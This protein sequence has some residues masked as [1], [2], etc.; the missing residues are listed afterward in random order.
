MKKT[1]LLLFAFA[2]GLSSCEEQVKS[3]DSKEQEMK[4]ESTNPLLMEST[5]DYYAPDFSKI[6][7]SHYR[8]ALEEGIR[9]KRAEIEE[10]ANQS[11]EPTFENTLVALERSGGDLKRVRSVFGALTSAHTNDTLQALKQEFAPIFSELN[12]EVYLNSALFD[13]I[14]TLYD[15]KEDLSLDAESAKLLDEYYNDFVLAGAELEG[16]AKEKLKAVNSEMASLVAKFGET[17]LAA[18]N[19]GALIVENAEELKGL[20]ESKLK[21]IETE[22]GNYKIAIQNTTQQ[23]TLVALENRKMRQKVFENAWY[24]TDG[25]AHDTKDII[26]KIAQKRAEKAA[27]LGYDSYA[28]WSLQNTMIQSKSNLREFFDGLI[29]AAIEKASAE[30]QLIE[31]MMHREGQEG[32]LEPW[33]WNFYAE[34]VRKEKYDLDENEIKPY[35]EMMSVLENGVFYAAEKL[36]G[37]TFKERTD[38][39][40][41][42]EDVLVY[43]LFE[44]DGSKLG[45]FYADFYSRES[46]RGGAWMGNFVD[47]SHLLGK[48]PVI[49]NVCNYPKPAEGEPTLLSFDNA[50]T[51]FH[52]FGHALHGFFANQEYPSLSGT[53]VARDFVEFPSQF[54][55]NWATHPD[56]LNNYAKHYETGEVIPA[57]LL[58]KIQEAATFNQG[59]SITENLAASNLDYAWHTISADKTIEDANQFEKDALSKYGVDKVRAVKPRYRSTYFAHIFAGGYGAGYYSYLWTEM[60]HHDAYVWFENNGGLTRENGQRYRDMVLSVGNTLQYDELYRDWSGR[61]PKIEPMIKARGLK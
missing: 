48:K 24:R 9:L 38:I 15:Q 20:S 56:V 59:Y 30:S 13:R 40:V 52:E 44:E 2:V 26:V 34:K 54:N 23:P 7:N 10:I 28:D 4:S 21:S 47:Q 18:T 12:D 41:Y 3:N 50:I 6:K 61:D 53:A 49:Y 51:M 19:E 31:E 58:A 43:E 14:K 11:E 37:I 8:S 35:F 17:L 27:L 42:H 39:P 45:L 25:S 22:D 16:E 33:D 57:E 29:P 1:S 32:Q 46:K 60:L 5:L 36:Y 55:E